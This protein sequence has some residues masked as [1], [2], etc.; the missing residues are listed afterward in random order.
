MKNKTAFFKALDKLISS[1]FMFFISNQRKNTGCKETTHLLY[2]A[3][4]S[5]SQQQ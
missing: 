3:T 5:L 2:R 1:R 4:T